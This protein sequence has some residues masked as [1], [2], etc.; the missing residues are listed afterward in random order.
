MSYQPL[1]EE[2]AIRTRVRELGKQISVDY[3]G[4]ELLLVGILKGAFIFMADLIRQIE[5]PV[6]VDFVVVSSYGA[7]TESSGVVRID[8]DLEKGIEGKHVL[9]V[10][11]I[12]DTGLTLNYLKHNLE[13]R[14]PASVRICALLDKPSRRKVSVEADYLGFSIADEFVVGYGLDFA[15]R[16]RHLPYVAVLSADEYRQS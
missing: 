8:K 5:V 2:Q 11:D 6:T 10:E 16:H 15:E 3:E 4:K 12:I 1:L 13:T 14:G 7:S 9:I